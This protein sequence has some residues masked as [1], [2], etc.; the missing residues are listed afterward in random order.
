MVLIVDT[1]NHRVLGFV[2][3]SLNA[4]FL[5]G[6]ANFSANSPNQGQPAPSASSLNSPTAVAID[7]FDGLYVVDSGNVRVLYFP[8]GATS[9][10]RVIGQT[11]FNTNFT[12]LS[13]AGFT[14]PFRIALGPAL[15]VNVSDVI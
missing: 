10:T 14:V 12:S 8:K 4:S 9:A 11:A 5:L 3:G 6:Q 13:S 15:E 2:G 7:P 1:G